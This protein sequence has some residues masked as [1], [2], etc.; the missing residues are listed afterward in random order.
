[1]P[2]KP[3][4]ELERAAAV[5][6][7]EVRSVKTEGHNLIVEIKV[8]K[9]WKGAITRTVV[10]Q[11][12]NSGAACG[13][14]FAEGK[15]YLVYAH[16]KGSLSVSLCSRTKPLESASEDLKELGDGKQPN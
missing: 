4:V 10:V 3:R 9:V 11:T 6:A 5:F 15:K 8:E 13:Y 2:D 16:G 14:S 1:M 7:G 12:A